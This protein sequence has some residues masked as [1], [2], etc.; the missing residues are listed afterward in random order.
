MWLPLQATHAA[1]AVQVIVASVGALQVDNPAE[2]LEF[3]VVLR[4]PAD[5]PP[6][7]A[8]PL[9]PAGESATRLDPQ[10]VRAAG[11]RCVQCV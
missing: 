3:P 4:V 5:A 6:A 7:D 10:S 2:E 11:V 9:S 8:P 1:R